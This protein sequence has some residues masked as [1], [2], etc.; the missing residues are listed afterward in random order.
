MCG[1]VESVLGRAIDSVVWRFKS[2]LPT[3]FPVAKGDV[4]LCGLIADVDVDTGR[5]VEIKRVSILI[6]DAASGAT[7]S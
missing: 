2:G 5:C 3:R 1:P 7:E 6:D 4:R